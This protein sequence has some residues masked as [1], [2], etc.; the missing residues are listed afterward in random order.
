MTTKLKHSFIALLCIVFCILPATILSINF[1]P[2][3]TAD[4][5]II[6]PIV[7]PDDI[8]NPGIGTDY[9]QPV[10]KEWSNSTGVPAAKPNADGSLKS[11]S[12]LYVKND[13]FFKVYSPDRRYGSVGKN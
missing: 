12:S 10:A 9:D 5:V 6:G 8:V 13:K 3:Q 4:A 2:T 11:Y 7:M 1:M